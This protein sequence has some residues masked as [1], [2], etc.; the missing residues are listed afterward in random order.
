MIA[1]G[2]LILLCC[3]AMAVVLTQRSMRDVGLQ[4]EAPSA[5]EALAVIANTPTASA[6]PTPPPTLIVP[7]TPLPVLLP[8]VTPT[9]LPA[10]RTARLSGIRH[11]W[12]T[13]NNCGP[14]TLAMTLSYYGS[15]L[16]QAEAGVALRGH[17]DDK[18]VSPAELIEFA[19]SQGFQARLLINGNAAQLRRLI[20]AGIPV[21]IETWLDPEDAGGLGHYRL[22]V[23]Y[24]DEVGAWIA[25][26]SYVG[27]NLVGLADDYQGIWLPYDET[28]TLW[29]VFNRT[30]V[31]IFEDSDLAAVD[32]LLGP[33]GDDQTMWQASVDRA[34][35]EI[36]RNEADAFTWF[37][38][39]TGLTAL[40]QFMD[41]SAAYDRAQQLGL[42]WR[43]L[44]YQFGPF[45]A[46]FHVGRHQDV[47]NLMESTLSPEVQIEELLYWR[48]RSLRALG[49]TANADLAWQRA[50]Q[51]NPAYGEDSLSTLPLGVHLSSNQ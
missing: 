6:S 8:T 39:G 20:D 35:A 42:P 10:V 11:M 24:N 33:I 18:N 27:E 30:A 16:S 5:T 50:G 17:P 15:Q 37:N 38:L 40:G 4:P 46:Y 19:R 44:W 12:Q 49:D 48:S 3:A 41:A 1:T 14:A 45:E 32:A 21:L 23:G 7:S 31:V 47:I 29:K 9:P 26:D 13:W 22:I 43:M 34:R 25:Y 51:L 2:I 36:E 28:E